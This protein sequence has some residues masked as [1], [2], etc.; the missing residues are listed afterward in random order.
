MNLYRVEARLEASYIDYESPSWTH[1]REHSIFVRQF[2]VI[3]ETPK[4]KWI[5]D[6]SHKRWVGNDTLRRFAHPTV[7]EAYAAFLARKKKQRRILKN[8][9]NDVECQISQVETIIA[10]QSYA[11]P[12]TYSLY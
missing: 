7:P 12:S 9:L 1:I 8:Q 2:P 6:L 11:E 4:G 10:N 5:K 3:K